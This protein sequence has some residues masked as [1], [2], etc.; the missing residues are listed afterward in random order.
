[1]AVTDPYKCDDC[2]PFVER[3]PIATR[4]VTFTVDELRAIDHLIDQASG[5]RRQA[6]ASR[7]AISARLKCSVAYSTIPT[8][9]R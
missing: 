2:P 7:P 5:G 1:M 4:T 6:D 8:H 9:Q 3:A